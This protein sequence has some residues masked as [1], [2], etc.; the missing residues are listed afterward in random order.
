MVIGQMLLIVQCEGILHVLLTAYFTLKFTSCLVYLLFSERVVRLLEHYQNRLRN[1]AEDYEELDYIKQ[2]LASSIFQQYLNEGR[3]GGGGTGSGLSSQ[4]HL[5]KEI[6]QASIDV[7]SGIESSNVEDGSLS[8]T[9]KRKR[10]IHRKQSLKALRNVVVS[11]QS[12][13]M[14]AMPAQQRVGGGGGV[15]P[16][17][18]PPPPQ[19]S[20]SMENRLSGS[21]L[22]EGTPPPVKGPPLIKQAAP[23]LIK[24]TTLESRSKDPTIVTS[25]SQIEQASVTSTPK[26]V[27]TAINGMDSHPA[28]PMMYNPLGDHNPSAIPVTRRGF[29]RFPN[30]VNSSKPRP[31]SMASA[32][33]GPFLYGGDFPEMG[34]E[35]RNGRGVGGGG[36]GR[37]MGGFIGRGKQLPGGFTGSQPN[38]SMLRITPQG[39]L[40]FDDDPQDTNFGGGGMMEWNSNQP[41]VAPGGVGGGGGVPIGGGAKKLTISPIS[42]PTSRPPP[43]SYFTHMVSNHTS[44]SS[45][46]KAAPMPLDDPVT[47]RAPPPYHQG[48]AKKSMG[49]RAR[50]YERLLEAGAELPLLAPLGSGPPIRPPIPLVPAMSDGLTTRDFPT[51]ERRKTSMVIRLNKGKEGLGF[52]L[53]GL[54][55]EQKGGVYVQDLQAGGSA[56]R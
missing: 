26:V 4:P 19:S 42:P 34:S 35:F 53:K 52:R 55:M 1:S 40:E 48:E 7:V 56:E 49:R 31:R 54:K 47:S 30:T 46:N 28:D 21:H 51:T 17:K 14:A 3:G 43:P 24:Q 11:K 20:S 44:P 32:V 39:G 23:P 50:S 38:I 45:V 10:Q 16:A 15:G 9:E 37:E 12:A 27:S 13:D 6:A 29:E 36:G 5:D 22:H 33:D 8:P 41:R 25:G 18:G 2:I